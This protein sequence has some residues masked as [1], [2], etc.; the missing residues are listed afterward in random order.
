MVP[1]RTT[2]HPARDGHCSPLGYRVDFKNMKQINRDTGY[3][4]SIMRRKNPA[5]EEG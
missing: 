1:S 3:K 2:V 5:F 4:R